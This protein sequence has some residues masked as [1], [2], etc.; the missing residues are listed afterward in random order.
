MARLSAHADRVFETIETGG[1]ARSRLAQSWRRSVENHGLDPAR[2]NA[3]HVIDAISLNSRM[4]AL[5]QLRRVAA[6]RLDKLYKLVG[7]SGCA[8]LLTDSEGIVL[9][10]RVG[11]GDEPVFR[12]WGL[13]NGADWSEEREG[14]NGIGTCLAERRRVIIHR[15]EHFLV[16]NTAMSCIDAPVYGADGRIIAAIDVSSA[17]VEQTEGFNRLIA[18]QL[19]Q[20]ARAIEE[21]NFHAAYEGA[22][23]LRADTDE[24][25]AAVLLAV[26]GDDLVI[27]AT[28]KARRIFG[29]A[30]EGAFAPRPAADLLGR[31]D[32][33]TGFEKAERAAVIRALSRASGNVSAAARAL[34]I[35]RA[36]LYRRMKRLG[37]AD[38]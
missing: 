7:L 37:I 25:D 1:A 12:G 10:Q 36:T 22:R 34:G 31:D 21:A 16:R 33:P 8:V 3:P 19:V 17:R 15:D 2:H 30:A 14:T 5:E 35:G 32:G 11:S 9:E 26:D 4:R 38:S 13:H 6:P 18:A 20:T 27:G 23:M 24:D 29:L 28:R